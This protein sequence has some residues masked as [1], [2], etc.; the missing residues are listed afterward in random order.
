MFEESAVSIFEASSNLP[1]VIHAELLEVSPESFEPSLKVGSK[2]ATEIGDDYGVSTKTVQTWFKAV[3]AAYPWIEPGALKTGRSVKTCYTSLCQALIAEYRA[4]AATVSEEDWIASVHAANPD[5]IQV[6]EVTDA[7]LVEE[8]ESSEPAS[9][10]ITL[11]P[12]DS[13]IA[14]HQVNQ[15]YLTVINTQAQVDQALA[16]LQTTLT[17][18]SQNNSNLESALIQSAENQGS[19]IGAKV[20]IAKVSKLVQTSEQVEQ[21]LAVQ[22]GLLGKPQPDPQDS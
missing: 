4:S 7:E 5:K 21:S 22:L 20:A 13:S 8:F 6:S 9:S 2:S 12:S 11:R 17:Q 3:R 1:E 16:T 10:A 18:W 15:I 14:V 19:E